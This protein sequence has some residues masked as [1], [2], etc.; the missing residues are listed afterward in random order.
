MARPVL[1]SQLVD[2]STS[3]APA[4]RG[5]AVL[6][7]EGALAKILPYLAADDLALASAAANG[8]VG[9]KPTY[10]RVSR[11]GLEAFASSLDQI[12]KI[13]K[14]AHGFHLRIMLKNRGNDCKKRL[15]TLN[16]QCGSIF[17]DQRLQSVAFIF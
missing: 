5:L 16:N 12:F 15:A 9:L 10:G 13:Q 11:Y 3:V 2:G 4:L 1:E 8:V 6:G 17:V 14:A 7:D